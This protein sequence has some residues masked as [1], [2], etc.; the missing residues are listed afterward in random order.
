[1]SKNGVKTYLFVIKYILDQCKTK[2]M[3][4]KVIIK[5]GGNLGFIP[6]C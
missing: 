2:E 1:M 6:D 5:N 3:C 4:N